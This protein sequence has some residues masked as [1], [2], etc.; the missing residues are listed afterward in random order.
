MAT[1]TSDRK[2]EY[3]YT[4]LKVVADNGGVMQSSEVM[5]QV[6]ALLN[7]TDYELERYGVSG[8]IRWTSVLRFNSVGLTK[9][10]WLRKDGGKWYVTDEGLTALNLSRSDFS[11]EAKRRYRL[12]RKERDAALG[13]IEDSDNIDDSDID[14]ADIT[15]S[16]TY[17]QAES[18]ANEEI[19]RF[20][21]GRGPY[22]FQDLVAALLR[23]MG[24]YTPF[25]APRGKDG[26]ID[27]IAYRDP[28]GTIAPRIIVQ[29]KHR[30]QKASVQEI[31]ELAGLLG[32]DGD[33]GL[34]VS[35]GGFTSDAE[36]EITRSVR[37]MEKMD[38]ETFIRFWKRHYQTMDEADR[39]LLPLSNIMFLAPAGL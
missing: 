12:W 24:Y 27:V 5:R 18:Q 19:E 22:E 10:G 17:E 13:D 2:S 23:G 8:H 6:G 21:I 35:T 7:L 28:L 30:Q 36:H 16:F 3:L 11:D 33:N 37:H 20:I 39:A 4:A 34:F 15:R 9:A 29:V 31:R 38:L 25:I 26:G 1:I 14:D 32:R